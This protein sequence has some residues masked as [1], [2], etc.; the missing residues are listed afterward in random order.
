VRISQLLDI[1]A[2][3][4]IAIGLIIAMLPPQKKGRA[5]PVGTAL[6]YAAIGIAVVAIS[7]TGHL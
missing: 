3:I 5:E 2:L 4:F 6:L 1:I 7:I